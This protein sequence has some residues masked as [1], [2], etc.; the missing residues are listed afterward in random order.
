LPL[1]RRPCHP[2]PG[3]FPRFIMRRPQSKLVA[4]AGGVSA[5]PVGRE[6]VEI[7]IAGV[8]PASRDEAREAAVESLKPMGAVT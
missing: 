4:V 5:L 1:M 2:L 6:F 8:A 3:I 7:D